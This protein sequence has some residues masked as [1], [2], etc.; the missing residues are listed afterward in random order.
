MGLVRPRGAGAEGRSGGH[1]RVRRRDPWDEEVV[2]GELDGKVAMVTGAAAGIGRATALRLAA[3]GARL[4][5]ADLDEERGAALVA[6]V[7]AAADTFQ[8]LET[9]DLA[10]LNELRREQGLPAL[11]LP[12]T[13]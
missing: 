6:E 4:G 9:I 7:E 1:G 3:E 8:R 13:V 10:A 11:L 5:V 2:M 12:A